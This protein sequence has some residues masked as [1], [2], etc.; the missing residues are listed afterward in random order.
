MA[1]LDDA[2]NVQLVQ[3][4]QDAETMN[5]KLRQQIAKLREQMSDLKKELKTS[6]AQNSSSITN[7][8]ELERLREQSRTWQVANENLQSQNKSLIEE[9]ARLFYFKEENERLRLEHT[10]IQEQQS[11]NNETILSKEKE[12]LQARARTQELE[13]LKHEIHQR[14]QPI[15]PNLNVKT[16]YQGDVRNWTP[17]THKPYTE[18]LEFIDAQY[19]STFIIGYRDFD[20][21]FV[22]I[23]SDD[24]CRRAFEVAQSHG[25]GNL[26][27]SIELRVE[28]K[29]NQ[30]IVELQLRE[31]KLHKK[32]HKWKKA[33]GIN[34][35]KMKKGSR[36][37]DQIF[38]NRKKD[39]MLGF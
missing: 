10:H 14:K 20:G 34:G 32:L 9:N 6:K 3:H 38:H 13:R 30:Q 7:R 4:L 19:D 12:L 15:I 22:R 29:L 36:L 23:N 37:L 18:L 5:L 1:Q 2:D 31:K 25:W 26:K 11:R 39:E 35:T 16:T 33:N 28:K 21:D 24:S 27:I 17:L 8:S